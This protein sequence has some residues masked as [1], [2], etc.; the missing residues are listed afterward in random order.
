MA[1][2][3]KIDTVAL[4]NQLRFFNGYGGFTPDG[5]E[6][7]IILEEGQS[8]PAPWINVIANEQFGFLATETGGGYTWAKNSRENRLTPWTNDPVIPLHG[9]AIFL[10]DQE[11]GQIWSP[12]AAPIRGENPYVTRHGFG[13]TRYEYG[14]QGLHQTVDLYAAANDPVKLIRIRLQNKSN[15]RRSLGV[16]YYLEP[17]LG[18]LPEETYQ[19]VVTDFDP[20]LNGLV[21]TNR[22]REHY[23]DHVA[24]LATLAEDFSYTGDRLEF[25]GRNGSLTDP[26]GL[27]Q[28]QLS[29]RVGAAMV[30]CAAILVPVTLEPGAS[31]EVTFLLGECAT[32][33]EAKDLVSRFRQEGA[34]QGEFDRVRSNWDELI[35]RLMVRTPEPSLDYLINGW[36]L[37]QVISCRYW[38]RSAFYQ[39][40]GAYGYRDQ[41]QDVMSL[42][43]TSPQ[44]TREHILRAAAHQFEEGD[45][46]HWWH[47]E[48]NK[49][50]R[51]RFSDDY[52]WLPFVTARYVQVTGD[53]GVLDEEVPYLRSRL[54][55]E[56][57]QDR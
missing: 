13:Y 19:Y 46:Q 12:T 53:T 10:R 57:E 3:Y 2:D 31:T 34:V 16:S 4:V 26:I 7:V 9:E 22:A 41:L 15:R 25:L 6:Y 54:L 33:Q 32:W 49:G 18:V 37:Y 11:T 38:G 40:G 30:P 56:H 8:T 50:V 29:G 42:V 14:D 55:E 44:I 5:K 35:G 28:V 48:E 21:I 52:L 36:L 23:W 24:F 47:P 43:Y 45:V 51:T 17:V 39:S 1:Y 27:Q 20:Q